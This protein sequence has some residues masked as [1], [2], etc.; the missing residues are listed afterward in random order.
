M[1]EQPLPPE[2]APLVQAWLDGTLSPEQAETLSAALASQP[3][4]AA[5]LASQ[6]AVDAMLREACAATRSPGVLSF[7]PP[8]ATSGD[9]PAANRAQF[10]KSFSRRA[11]PWLALAAAIALIAIPTLRWTLAPATSIGLTSG[12]VLIERDG[13]EMLVK[14]GAELRAGDTLHTR[15]D[16]RAEI[17]FRGEATRLTLAPRTR[18][19]VQQVDHGRGFHLR[20]GTITAEIAPQASDHP[21]TFVTSRAFAAVRGTRFSLAARFG[22]TWLR[23]E[24]GEVDISTTFSE[25]SST[26]VVGAGQFA[27]AAPDVTLQ[28][29]PTSADLDN[30]TAPLDLDF[31]GGMA[32]G[33]GTW[34]PVPGGLRS[35]DLARFSDDRQLGDGWIDPT[36]PRAYSFYYLPV[37]VRG[38]LRLCAEVEVQAVTPDRDE[39]GNLNLWRF[40]FGLRYPHREISLRANQRPEGGALQTRVIKPEWRRFL[41]QPMEGAFEAP[42]TVV[43]GQR[44]R[45]T[46]EIRRQSPSRLRLLGKIWPIDESEPHTWT[47]DTFIDDV[48]GDLG[49]VNLDTYRAIC[50]FR[51]VKAELL[52]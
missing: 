1:P 25:E 22:A 6:L 30:L 26:V 15:A 23:V 5:T 42:F 3:E 51:D 47:V 16:A 43:A 48:Q 24:E 38:S 19:A 18:L 37:T 20:H 49:A 46:W 28:A 2:L 8:D 41:P 21:M 4:L 33:V 14:A 27:V 44:Y 32:T 11:L 34:E 17:V 52:P 35:T 12:E 31:D 7:A 50:A 29:R 36:K 40:G 10:R 39:R 45:L 9:E 13:G